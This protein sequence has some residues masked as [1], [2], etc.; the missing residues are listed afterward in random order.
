MC[1]YRRLFLVLI[2]L[3]IFMSG[4][5]NYRSQ[6]NNANPTISSVYEDGKSAAD[7]VVIEDDSNGEERKDNENSKADNENSVVEYVN[8][9]SAVEYYQDYYFH[10]KYLIIEPCAITS[11]VCLESYTSIESVGYDDIVRVEVAYLD[12]LGFIEITDKAGG[13][14]SF[15]L[16]SG[17][18]KEAEQMIGSNR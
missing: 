3:T 6:E 5:V 7:S 14:F 18:A 11:Y 9:V 16:E 2:L 10:E 12:N 15:V 4:C 17:T 8:E 13:L 1:N